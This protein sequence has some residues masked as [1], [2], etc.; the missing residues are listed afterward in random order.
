MGVEIKVK[1]HLTQ[2]TNLKLKK[3]AKISPRRGNNSGFQLSNYLN[4]IMLDLR[5]CGPKLSLCCMVLSCW[6][7]V[8]LSIMALAFYSRSVA[9]VE[10]VHFNETVQSQ[11]EYKDNLEKAYDDQALNCGIAVALYVV[12]LLV[13]LHQYW[14]NSRA[15]P[16]RYQ[17]HY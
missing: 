11:E 14:L 5:F 2:N 13:S 3:L 4:I 9:F 10:D 12:T 16:N 1:I 15:T 17:R 8:Q 7:I 6:G